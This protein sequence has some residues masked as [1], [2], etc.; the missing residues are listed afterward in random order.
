MLHAALLS[1]V[2]LNRVFVFTLRRCDENTRGWVQSGAVK[3]R[4][5][6]WN[7]RFSEALKAICLADEM[8]HERWCCAMQAARCRLNG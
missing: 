1:C 2:F 5:V 3:E 6:G 4:W 7:E 8:E